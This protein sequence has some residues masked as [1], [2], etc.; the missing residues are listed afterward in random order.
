VAQVVAAGDFYL[1]N[2][3]VQAR[4]STTFEGGTLNDIMFGAHLE[5][6]GSL[7]GGIV[8]AT[9]V[10]LEREFAV[11]TE[12]YAN[13]ATINPSDNTLTLIGQR[14]SPPTGLTLAP[15]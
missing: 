1:G 2:V 7:V 9:K 6:H 14:N 8:N 3:H 10:K 11:E 12:R 15:A 13:V 5:A 4:G